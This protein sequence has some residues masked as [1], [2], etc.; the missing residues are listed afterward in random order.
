[1]RK[2]TYPYWNGKYEKLL[3]NGWNICLIAEQPSR[4]W[5]KIFKR[6]S[7]SSVGY[8]ERLADKLMGK[9]NQVKIVCGYDK[10]PQRI[11]MYSILYK[12]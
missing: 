2:S 10:N 7:T 1:M 5:G 8:V 12:T 6:H 11:K 4:Q 3:Q 9:G